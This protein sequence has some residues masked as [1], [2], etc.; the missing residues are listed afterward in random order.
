MPLVLES[1]H[2]YDASSRAAA[3]GLL[4]TVVRC[5]H[6]RISAHAGFLWGHLISAFCRDLPEA[7]DIRVK[8]DT[9]SSDSENGV[10]GSPQQHRVVVAHNEKEESDWLSDFLEAAAETQQHAVA[11]GALLSSTDG[12]THQ[13]A[14]PSLSPLGANFSDGPEVA[15]I[16]NILLTCQV[17]VASTAAWAGSFWESVPPSDSLKEN[18]DSFL[19]QRY[20]S[21]LGVS[22]D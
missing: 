20:V 13:L 11:T 10:Q 16:H 18:L 4:L 8:R 19:L 7:R 5:T 2:A 3:S 12:A 22:K 6:Q 15:V 21:R 14:V 9:C 1:L 17:L